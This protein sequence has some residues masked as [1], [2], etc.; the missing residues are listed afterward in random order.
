MNLKIGECFVGHD[1]VPKICRVEAVVANGFGY[2]DAV[3]IRAC[4][5]LRVELADECEASQKWFVEAHAFFFGEADDFDGERK[6]LAAQL[7]DYSDAEHNAE[8][9][10]EGAGVGDG[11]EVG[12][13]EKAW[14]VRRETGPDA[15]QIAHGVDAH[16]HSCGLHPIFQECVYFVHRWR[17]EEA[18]YF[19]RHIGTRGKLPAAGDDAVGAI[20][21]CAVH[22]YLFLD[23]RIF[24]EYVL[25][26]SHAARRWGRRSGSDC[27]G[28]SVKDRPEGSVY[29]AW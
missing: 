19:A 27:P 5:G 24:D 15:A 29:W 7:L 2:S 4:E 12:A 28:R 3:S 21:I 1:R 14:G 6:M 18:R 23:V 17:E 11:V 26:C 25:R 9:A 20:C 22:R 13:D 16:R 10:V 8:D